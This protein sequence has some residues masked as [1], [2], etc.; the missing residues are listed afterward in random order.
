MPLPNSLI[1]LGFICLSLAACRGDE[2]I[3]AY[4]AADIKWQLAEIDGQP[5]VAAATLHFPEPGRIT[6]V[7][8]CNSYSADL[9]APYPW[10]AAQHLTVTRMACDDLT[11]E[12]QFLQALQ[13]MT[14]SEVSGNTLI[15]SNVAGREMVFTAAE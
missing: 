1:P 4:G 13:D 14:L 10:F 7:A 2:T 5:F 12:N 8:P 3:A 9:D 11:V 15:L 6:G